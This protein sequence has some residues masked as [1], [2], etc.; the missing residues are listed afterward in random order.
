MEIKALQDASS[1]HRSMEHSIAEFVEQALAD[2]LTT[3]FTNLKECIENIKQSDEKCE[4]MAAVVEKASAL[5]ATLINSVVT[6]IP[7]G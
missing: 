3:D 2:S 1:K 4:G 5:V 7:K 6:V